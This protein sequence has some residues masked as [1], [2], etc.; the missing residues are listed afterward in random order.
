MPYSH[1]PNVPVGSTTLLCTGCRDWSDA[2]AI[3]HQLRR[4]YFYCDTQGAKPWVVVGDANGADSIVREWLNSRLL[5]YT[6][7]DADWSQYGKSAGPRRN[8][9]MVLDGQPDYAVAFWDN[10]SR[11]T[12]NCIA[13]CRDAGVPVR[14]VTSAHSLSA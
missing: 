7:Y 4:F 11:G 12:A 2:Q 14:I 13:L 8:A 3:D 9:Q 5:P 1:Y 6:R 10:K